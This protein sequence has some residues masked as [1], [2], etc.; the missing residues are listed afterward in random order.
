MH[1]REWTTKITEVQDGLLTTRGIDQEAL[2]RA[3]SFEQ[4]IF[5][6]LQGREAG[7]TECNL[8]RAVLVSHLSH[9]I[10][11]QSTLAV[12][13]AADCRSGFLN[14]LIGGFS[15]G[16][17]P[18]HQGGLRAAMDDLVWFASL[19]N[20]GETELIQERIEQRGA[21]FGF[22]H[23]YH[24]TGDPRA[25]TLMKMAFDASLP[26][27][28][29][30]AAA[31]LEKRLGEIKSI[32][33]NIEAACAAILLDLGFEPEISHLFII[34]GRSAMFAAAYQERILQM[35]KPFGRIT[36]SDQVR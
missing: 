14:A 2:I 4:V 29:V 10:T 13:M 5:L 22:G 1:N 35:P 18:F 23:R 31:R 20:D 9:G 34:L 15:V 30:N 12:R 24:R 25:K 33:M 3:A 11:G 8:L 27:V 17:G 26:G 32:S 19:A 36:V 21:I 6:I 28:Y 16:S 7:P